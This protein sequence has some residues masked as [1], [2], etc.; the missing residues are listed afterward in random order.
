MRTQRPNASPQGVL[1]TDYKQAWAQYQAW[2]NAQ[3][4]IDLR[5]PAAV[6]ADIECLYRT[7]PPEVR[8]ADP[9]P[10]KKGVQEMYRGFALLQALYERNLKS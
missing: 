3:G 4:E 9:D 10:E 5:P 2:S 6:L 1:S 8:V 7:L